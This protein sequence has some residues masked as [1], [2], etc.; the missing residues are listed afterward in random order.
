[1]SKRTIKWKEI[2]HFEVEVEVPESLIEE[3]AIINWFIAQPVIAD[4]ADLVD[5][6]IDKTT[7]QVE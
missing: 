7:F 4:E 3:S 2:H 1:V 5:L 6:T